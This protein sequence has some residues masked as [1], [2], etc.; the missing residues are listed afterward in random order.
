[1]ISFGAYFVSR[2]IG[3]FVAYIEIT[4]GTSLTSVME[5]ILKVISVLIPRTDIFAKTNIIL[6]GNLEYLWIMISQSIIYTILLIFA[7]RIDFSKR[8][9]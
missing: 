1:M 3:S 5:S 9:F 7:T 6:Y 2:A 8:Q 4:R